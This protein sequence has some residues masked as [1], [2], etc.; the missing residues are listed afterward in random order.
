M[1]IPGS[2]NLEEL[3]AALRELSERIERFERGNVDFHGRRIINAGDAIASSD[4]V[5]LGQLQG[6]TSNQGINSQIVY[7]DSR[8]A[9]ATSTA[10]FKNGILISNVNN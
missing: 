6:Q 5:T 1:K 4:Y 10:T 2:L 8:G 7:L 3:Q 9:G